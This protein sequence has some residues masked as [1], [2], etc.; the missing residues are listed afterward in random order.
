MLEIQTIKILDPGCSSGTFLVEAH[1]RSAELKP[2]KSFSQIKHVPEDVHRQILRQLY[3]EDINEFPAHL[4]AMNLAM[5][6]VRVPSTEMYIFVRDYF[7]IIP[8]HSILAPFRTRTPE[9]EKQVEVVFKDFD[10]VVG[11]PPYTRWA[12]IPENIQSLILDVLKTTILKYD[13]A[14]QV[15]RSVEPGIYVYWIMHSTG[16]LKDG[17][18]LSMIIK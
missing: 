13:L 9:G 3:S 12:E 6:N 10:A 17:G 5:K 14:P 11:N 15:L 16:F 18:R 8:G 1:K 7:T 4:T 2:K